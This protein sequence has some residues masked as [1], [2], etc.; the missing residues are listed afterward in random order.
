MRE[1]KANII[2]ISFAINSTVLQFVPVDADAGAATAHATQPPHPC[3]LLFPT[4]FHL[5]RH[6]SLCHEKRK[7][8][9]HFIFCVHLYSGCILGKIIHKFMYIFIT[10]T[11]V[12]PFI[13]AL[14]MSMNVIHYSTE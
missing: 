2:C 3:S 11:H 14:C 6:I 12:Y 4:H 8:P 13:H 10:M 1:R 7:I 5:R 9:C